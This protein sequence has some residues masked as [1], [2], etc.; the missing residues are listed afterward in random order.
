MKEL[1]IYNG[2]NTVITVVTDFGEFVIP[3]KESRLVKMEDDAEWNTGDFY[4]QEEGSWHAKDNN[5]FT[6]C[7]LEIYD[8]DRA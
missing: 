7:D 1:D 4:V 2:E 8:T 5:C 3:A 6:G